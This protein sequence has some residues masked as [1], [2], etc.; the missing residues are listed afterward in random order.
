M[1][2]A[3]EGREWRLSMNMLPWDLFINDPGHTDD[4]G[5][6]AAPRPIEVRRSTETAFLPFRGGE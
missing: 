4:L 6:H 5:F 1:A 3:G 2:G